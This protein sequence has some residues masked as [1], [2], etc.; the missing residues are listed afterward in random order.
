MS[1]LLLVLGLLLFVG[2]VVL[3]E[4]GHFLEARRA[5]VVV[6]EFGI[7][8]PPKVWAKKTKQGFLFTINLLPLGGFVRLK[9]ENDSA[10]S[11]GSFGAAKLSA[12]VRVMLAGIVM[13]LVAALAIFTLLALTGMPKLFDDQFSVPSDTKIIRKVQNQDVVLVGSVAENSP[14]DQAG[15]KKG[16]QILKVGEVDIASQELLSQTTEKY[17]GQEVEITVKR[18]EETKL[19]KIK[20]NGKEN[21]EQGYLGIGTISGASGIELRRSTWSAPIVALGLTKQFTELTYKGIGSALS[22]LFTGNTSKASEQVSGPVGIFVILKEGS[23]LG[24]HFI[25]MVIGILSL[26]L[27]LINVLPIPALD[28]GR[29]FVMMLFRILKKPLNKKTEEWIHG[30]GFAMLMFLF[31]LITIVD[32]GRLR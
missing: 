12:K 19:L 6:E 7:G 23:S 27:A 4:F 21:A 13:N 26:T 9:G 17:A 28:G 10:T 3:H 11:E 1:I 31:V 30:L 22:N 32:V 25:L 14:A 29:L 2:L 16:D 20:L 24:I 18:L 15:L 8:F 5:G